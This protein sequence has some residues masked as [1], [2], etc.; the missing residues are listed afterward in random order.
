MVSGPLVFHSQ[1]V[2][3]S[4]S[5]LEVNLTQ[6]QGLKLV[7]FVCAYTLILRLASLC[8]RQL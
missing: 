2:F 6:G 1:C 8:L 7:S 3:D 5:S 4:Y